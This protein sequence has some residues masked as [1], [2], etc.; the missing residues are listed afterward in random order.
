MRNNKAEISTQLSEELQIGHDIREGLKRCHAPAR[1]TPQTTRTR[2]QK[3]PQD[4]VHPQHL[5][6]VFKYGVPIESDT[7]ITAELQ[8]I[9]EWL[10]ERLG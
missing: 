3:D 9:K 4:T 8:Q 2:H 10:K 7:E 1:L 6:E 5:H